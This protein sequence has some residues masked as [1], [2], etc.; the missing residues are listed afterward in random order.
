MISTTVDKASVDVSKLKKLYRYVIVAEVTYYCSVLV[1]WAAFYIDTIHPWWLLVPTIPVLGARIR[2]FNKKMVC[3]NC[4]E[5]LV[6][7]ENN[8]HIGKSCE[9]C[10]VQF[11]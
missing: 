10:G 9:H 11:R 3:P 6:D 8:I 7:E 1:L 4:K 2:F 5:R